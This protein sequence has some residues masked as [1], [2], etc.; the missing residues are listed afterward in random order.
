MSFSN[1][2]S[3]VLFSNGGLIF[4]WSKNYLVNFWFPV[5][6]IS[7]ICHQIFKCVVGFVEE[8]S[9]G[10]WL[11]QHSLHKWQHGKLGAERQHQQGDS[12]G[13]HHLIGFHCHEWKHAVTI[14]KWRHFAQVI[15]ILIENSSLI[16]IPLL[17]CRPPE[18]IPHQIYENIP[19]KER[20]LPV[21]C[22]SIN[23]CAPTSYA[24]PPPL[25]RK[26]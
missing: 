23:I 9:D 2:F 17:Y 1:R 22:N 4:I 24:P 18:D 11:Q 7:L 8:S 21:N 19:L 12:G 16:L 3:Y 20:K 14:R 15:W 13:V 5:K 10:A 26:P 6:Q 25:P